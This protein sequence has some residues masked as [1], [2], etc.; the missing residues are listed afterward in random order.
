M[1]SIA[2]SAFYGT[3]SFLY[4]LL[5]HMKTDFYACRFEPFAQALIGL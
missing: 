5:Y 1:N 4:N 3:C 2:T